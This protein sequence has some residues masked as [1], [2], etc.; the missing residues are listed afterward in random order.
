MKKKFLGSYTSTTSKEANQTKRR[1][2]Q[3]DANAVRDG[4]ASEEQ[5]ARFNVR[6][7]LARRKV[8]CTVLVR[9]LATEKQDFDASWA[10]DYNVSNAFVACIN[11]QISKKTMKRVV[12]QHVKNISF[13][14]KRSTAPH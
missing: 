5:A 1:R 11:W 8:D 7:S 14:L 2:E 12:Q 9:A 10:E 6:R 3:G 4:V 13:V